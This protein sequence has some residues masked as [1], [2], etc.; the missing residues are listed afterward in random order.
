MSLEEVL[1]A[2]DAVL[3]E[4][5]AACG[6]LDG[7]ES[8]PCVGGGLAGTEVQHPPAEA[9]NVGLASTEVQQPPE[10]APKVEAAPCRARSSSSSL[11]SSSSSR[12][13]RRQYGTLLGRRPRRKLA[14]LTRGRSSECN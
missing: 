7:E 5:L 3:A 2:Q 8:G 13:R 12:R 14:C 9:P 4:V 1:K 10:E 6:L 11:S